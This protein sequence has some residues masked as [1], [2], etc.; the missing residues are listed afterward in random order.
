MS[1][2]VERLDHPSVLAE[3]R[4]ESEPVPPR[5]IRSCS[6]IITD[7]LLIYFGAAG[8]R[9]TI[10]LRN[11]IISMLAEMTEPILASLQRIITAMHLP[12]YNSL[13]YFFTP[14]KNAAK[15]L[16]KPA[17]PRFLLVKKYM[18]APDDA[19]LIQQAEA[20]RKVFA[21]NTKGL[22]VDYAFALPIVQKWI[23]SDIWQERLLGII[24]TTGARKTAI[25]D[26]RI[27]F[28]E[29]DTHD[30]NTWVKQL[31]VLKDR[32]AVE[33]DTRYIPGKCPEKPL[34]F[35]VSFQTV[36]DAVS[37][38]RE[39]AGGVDL[40][41]KEVGAKYSKKLVKI[42]KKAFPGQAKISKRLGTHFLR[43]LYA[44]VAYHFF[45][46]VVGCS[47]TSF[48]ATV[49]GHDPN[50][51]TTALSYQSL[52]ISFGLPVGIDADPKKNLAEV[53]L[54]LNQLGARM[55]LVESK[56]QNTPRAPLLDEV[57][58]TRPDG[59]SFK[60]KK[61]T[62]LGRKMTEAEEDERVLGTTKLLVD[63]GVRATQQNIIRRGIGSALI[64]KVNKRRRV[65]Q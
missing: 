61:L 34:A 51:L 57:Q 24:A 32:S 2:F 16:W 54:L 11:V 41:R 55:E 20:D 52:K 19:Q 56:L 37:F 39:H 59:S 50:S 36:R 13:K 42:V 4:K 60:L 3:I 49:L 62:R 25:L 33:T 1:A 15:K 43:A 18:V 26:H 21:K 10:T 35:G 65:S 44:N 9:D 30:K 22:S 28:V 12:P 64:A 27:K 38:V 8:K 6:K 53:R 14:I 31:G 58:Y 48:I 45:A 17:D 23:I 46:E 29:A 40:K 63:N 47:L 5:K 7:A